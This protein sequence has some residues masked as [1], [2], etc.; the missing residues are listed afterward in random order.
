MVKGVT[1]Y[2]SLLEAFIDDNKEE[3]VMVTGVRYFTPIK[4]GVASPGGY[5]VISAD[6]QIGFVYG[7]PPADLKAD[8]LYDVIF[9]VDIYFGSYQMKAPAFINERE[10]ELPTVTPTEMTLDEIVALPKPLE[11]SFNHQYIKL[12]NVKVRVVD[13]NDRYKTFLVNQDLA[14]DAVL[15]DMN[16]CGLLS[17]KHWSC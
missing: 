1:S 2:S 13:P 7:N 9:D 12:V 11:K 16:R 5:Y 6:N 14:D 3:K 10:G 8:K 15:T 4:A 17:I